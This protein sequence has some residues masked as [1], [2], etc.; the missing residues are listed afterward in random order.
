MIARPSIRRRLGT[1]T[2]EVSVVISVFLLFLFGILEYCRFLLM[3]HV[4]TNAARDGARYAVVNVNKPTN[5]DTVDY[6]DGAT[7]F[8]SV[9]KYT[10]SKSSAVQQMLT[11]YTVSVFPC[12]MT[13]LNATPPVVVTKSGSPSWNQAQFGDRIAVRISGDYT[14]VLPNF[15][16]MSASIPINIAVTMNSE[17]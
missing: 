3:M 6:F 16:F 14:P 1:T 4:V 15:L 11:T 12:D 9:K 7:T 5:F 17:G 2:V 13:S 8:P 10:D